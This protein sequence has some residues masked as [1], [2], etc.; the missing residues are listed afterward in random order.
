MPDRRHI[1]D[2]RIAL[3]GEWRATT[4]VRE[5]RRHVDKVIDQ[6][7]AAGIPNPKLARIAVPST[8]CSTLK[9]GKL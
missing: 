8:I 7:H 5:A 4:Q 6:A 3:E 9:G 1:T 2:L